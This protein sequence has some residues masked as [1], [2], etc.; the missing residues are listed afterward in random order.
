MV[1]LIF[2]VLEMIIGIAATSIHPIGI[3]GVVGGSI[4]IIIFLGCRNIVRLIDERNYEEAKS[5][6]LMWMILGFIF[7]G[8]IPGILLLV[9]YLKLGEVSKIP[10]T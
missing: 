10:A 3:L 1:S 9:V 6:T 2:G 4:D 8:I 7:G 5:S